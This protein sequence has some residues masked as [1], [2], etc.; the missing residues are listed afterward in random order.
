MIKIPIKSC[1]ISRDTLFLND[2]CHSCNGICKY[3]K[4]EVL[5]LCELCYFSLDNNQCYNCLVCSVCKKFNRLPGYC[6]FCNEIFKLSSIKQIF[7]KHPNFLFKYFFQ[8]HLFLPKPT[9]RFITIL[10]LQYL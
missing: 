7:K 1:L 10:V 2:Q 6:M 8:N 5:C 3:P 9:D 4:N